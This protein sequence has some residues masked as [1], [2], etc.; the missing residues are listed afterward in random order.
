LKFNSDVLEVVFIDSYEL[1][2]NSTISN[3]LDIA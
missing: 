2:E 1:L 3:K